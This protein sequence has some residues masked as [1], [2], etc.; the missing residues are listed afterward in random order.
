MMTRETLKAELPATP[1]AQD[2][3]ENVFEG[4]LCPHLLYGRPQSPR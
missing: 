1:K 2:V 3:L 4:Q